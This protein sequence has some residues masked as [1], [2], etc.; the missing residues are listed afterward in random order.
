MRVSATRA[1]RSVAMGKRHLAKYAALSTSSPG[2]AKPVPTRSRARSCR[3]EPRSSRGPHEGEGRVLSA[4]SVARHDAGSA[5]ARGPSI[6]LVV[7]A[8]DDAAL[9]DVDRRD[10]VLVFDHESRRRGVERAR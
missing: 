8:A 10:D 7:E 2:Y 5:H 3:T 4:D 6:G 1:S 9:V